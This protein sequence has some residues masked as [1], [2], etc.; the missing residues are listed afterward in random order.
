MASTFSP[1][2]LSRYVIIIVI[3]IVFPADFIVLKLLLILTATMVRLTMNIGFLC[4][5]FSFHIT[6]PTPIIPGTTTG[7]FSSSTTTTT[8]T[9]ATTTT[10]TTA[11]TTTTTTSTTTTAATTTTT[12]STTT[13]AAATT[14]TTT[15]TT[16]AAAT[17]TTTTIT[18]TTSSGII[19]S[20]I[21]NNS[22][23]L[24]ELLPP[25]Y[26]ILPE[27]MNCMYG[28]VIGS[29]FQSTFVL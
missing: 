9:T 6:I 18:T 25:V 13:T 29:A 15:I 1:P 24:D 12:T 11:A 16:T 20:L 10:T 26:D 22:R 4:L 7:S 17:T 2:F 19:V 21:T 3:C 27:N 23:F 28:G 5:N 14:T 8:P